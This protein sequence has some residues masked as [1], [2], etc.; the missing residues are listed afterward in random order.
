MV[1]RFGDT[2]KIAQTDNPMAVRKIN[3]HFLNVLF[4]K[5]II[6]VMNTLTVNIENKKSEKTVKAVLDALG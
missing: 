5:C 2:K 1:F 6:L 4:K 3:Y